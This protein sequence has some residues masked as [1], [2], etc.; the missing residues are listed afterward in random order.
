MKHI[1]CLQESLALPARIDGG[2]LGKLDVMSTIPTCFN[3]LRRETGCVV[4]ELRAPADTHP[5]PRSQPGNTE[6]SE[7]VYWTF[8]Q[9]NVYVHNSVCLILGCAY[10]NLE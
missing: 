5:P 9:E 6:D 10:H 4:D 1:E 8:L 2:C 3:R 7:I